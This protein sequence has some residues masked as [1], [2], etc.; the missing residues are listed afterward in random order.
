[1]QFLTEQVGPVLL[2]LAAVGWYLAVLMGT[3]ALRRTRDS[4][5]SR[6][7]AAWVCTIPVVLLAVGQGRYE[8]AVGMIFATSVACMTLVLGIVTLAAGTTPAQASRRGWGM[9]LPVALVCF[10]M[11]LSGGFDLRDAMVLLVQGIAVYWMW[12]G[13]DEPA[14]QARAVPG[15]FGSMLGVVIIATL[16]GLTAIHA[17]LTMSPRMGLM[18][19]GLVTGLMLAPAMALPLI[20]L[21]LQAVQDGQ[22]DQFVSGLV[23]FVFLNLCLLLP[24]AALLWIAQP[25]RRAEVFQ[26][27][28]T[29]APATL[30]ATTSTTQDDPDFRPPRALPYPMAI[31]RVDT[32]LLIAVGL[33]LLPVSIGKWSLGRPEA[34]GLIL[35]W[36]VFM[37]LTVITTMTHW[38]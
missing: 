37:L 6:A 20:G 16:A 3:A 23:G 25:P 32:V 29:T 5:G 34:I 14:S 12:Q 24:L 26:L 13:P 19:G 1:M 15:T 27:E 22:Y 8:I 31:W 7:R 18:N 9:L 2:M 35:T 38:L 30:P 11:G 33:L 36:A 4:A 10:L 28:P 21:G 17:T